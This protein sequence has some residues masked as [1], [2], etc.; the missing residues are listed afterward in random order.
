MIMVR[1]K[2]WKFERIFFDQST[3]PETYAKHKLAKN[4]K[5]QK[6]KQKNFELDKTIMGLTFRTILC[7]TKNRSSGRGGD[8]GGQ[9]PFCK[10]NIKK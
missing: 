1:T 9:P 7:Y 4:L 5:K 3:Y 10:Y 8:D 6:Q 2:K